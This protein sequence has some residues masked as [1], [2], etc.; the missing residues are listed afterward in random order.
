MK[1]ISKNQ[2]NHSAYVRRVSIRA[3][4]WKASFLLVLIFQLSGC[5]SSPE[6]SPVR[7]DG[8]QEY[9]SNS[10]LST[11]D[12]ATYNA[13]IYSALR[14]R[15]TDMTQLKASLWWEVGL[16]LLREV[17]SRNSNYFEDA[18]EETLEAVRSKESKKFNLS[19]RNL[20]HA[21]AQRGVVINRI[22]HKE[23]ES[24]LLGLGEP[25]KVEPQSEQ[26][27]R[28]L[29]DPWWT[30]YN[31]KIPVV[32]TIAGPVITNRDLQKNYAFFD[33]VFLHPSALTRQAMKFD[34]HE[35]AFLETVVA[36]ELAHSLLQQ[37]FD[38][39]AATHIAGKLDKINQAMGDELQFVDAFSVIEFIAD[40]V[41]SR[42][43]STSI[44]QL[45]SRVIRSGGVLGSTMTDPASGNELM[46]D[47]HDASALFIRELMVASEAGHQFVES[48]QTLN[49][50][51]E[52][53]AEEKI[54]WPTVFW[55]QRHWTPYVNKIVDAEFDALV[56]DR[57]QSVFEK[58]LAVITT[59][60]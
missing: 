52:K 13:K 35:K 40:A 14:I 32:N 50:L 24:F 48:E 49:M 51:T 41:Q 58:I 37:M 57:Y 29:F 38:Y 27:V 33:L 8:A 46:I 59:D 9:T 42:L 53:I 22:F 16:D 43:G 31:L 25:Y 17:D 1:L 47:P 45:T 5:V 10:A 12:I 60:D 44:R 4:S 15:N 34:L 3:T 19:I 55:V 7:K 36:H 39:G 21:L 26:M 23:P 30:R 28:S 6:E 11:D 2:I 56:A 20:A 54:W 18:F